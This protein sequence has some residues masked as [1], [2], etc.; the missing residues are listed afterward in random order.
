M[1]HGVKYIS[2]LL[3]VHRMGQN[4]Q[5][6]LHTEVSGVYHISVISEQI[7]HE[8]LSGCTGHMKRGDMMKWVC[9]QPGIPRWLLT[10]LLFF[11]LETRLRDTGKRGEG[12][13]CLCCPTRV[14]PA[15]G[16]PAS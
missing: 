3:G 14:R 8:T 13:P 9:G 1:A 4:L 6:A 11:P 16:S 15:G 5:E 2:C 12:G 10:I 7:I